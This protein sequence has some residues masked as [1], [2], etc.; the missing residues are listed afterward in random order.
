MI[1]WCQIS[2]RT[3][4]IPWDDAGCLCPVG[5]LFNYAAPDDKPC[6]ED[7][8]FE[9][10]EVKEASELADP[11][12][13]RLTDG[14]YEENSASYCFY[15]KRNYKKGEQVTFGRLSPCLGFQGSKPGLSLFPLGFYKE[16]T[17]L[18]SH[19]VRKTRYL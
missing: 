17:S 9:S 11:D 12:T 2:S 13:Q 7:S 15:A 16:S 10:S 19:H 18:K 8:H 3:L 4:Y 14:G 6:A 5:D 1:F